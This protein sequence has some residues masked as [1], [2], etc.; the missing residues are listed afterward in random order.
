MG[1]KV[2]F[3]LS[4]DPSKVFPDDAESLPPNIAVICGGIESK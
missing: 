1:D 4:R 3:T 2:E